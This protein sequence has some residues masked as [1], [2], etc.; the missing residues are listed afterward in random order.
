MSDTEI[1]QTTL[2]NGLHLIGE[3]RSTNQSSS[4]GFFVKTGARD[5]SKREAGVSHFLEH[6]MFK[7]TKKRS[8]LDITFELGNLGA[9]ANAYTSEE[10]TVFYA[11]V[12]PEYFTE[13]QDLLT[14]MLRPSLDTHEFNTEKKVILEEIALYQDKP[15]FCL[16]EK[17]LEAYFD[18]HPAGNSVLGSHQSISDVTRDE[19]ASYFERRYSPANMTLVATGNFD[20]NRFVEA[21]Q[22]LTHSWIPR[23]NGRTATPYKKAN[24]AQLKF[25][26][27][28]LQASHVLLVSSGPAA[29]DDRRYPL[30]VLSLI[31]GDGSGSKLYW[32]LVET[33]LAETAILDA[34]EKD[35]TGCILAYATTSP[36]SLDTVTE[37]M[38]EVLSKPLEFTDA[39]LERAKAKLCSRVVLSGELPIGRLMA[40]GNDWLYREEV[41]TL[42]EIVQRIEKV[43][44]SEIEE[45]VKSFPFE[46][47][48]YRMVA[49]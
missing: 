43:S 48:E 27:K 26:K 3:P 10:T 30:T 19:M 14:D 2:Q 33:G 49:E 32:E 6:M 23:E 47:S 8:A 36:E 25:T 13:M 1:K 20:W 39:D 15:Q 11:T 22:K 16:F 17:G 42:K 5:E 18:G 12:L 34:D 9:Q 40:L 44:R 46:W 35:G 37:K 28:S 7:G 21:A 31:L 45:A 41:R 29:Q 4:I 38:K 24:A